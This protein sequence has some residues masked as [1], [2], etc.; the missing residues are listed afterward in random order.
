MK[1]ANQMK[2]ILNAYDVRFEIFEYACCHCFTFLFMSSCTFV[3]LQMDT[4]MIEIRQ[5]GPPSWTTISWPPCRSAQLIASLFDAQGGL[6]AI[7]AMQR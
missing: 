7:Q 2:P 4:V 1:Y 5:F 6:N 3:K